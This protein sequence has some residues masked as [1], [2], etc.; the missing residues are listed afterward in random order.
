MPTVA[1]IIVGQGYSMP[2]KAEKT[3]AAGL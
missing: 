2:A 1:A 3:V